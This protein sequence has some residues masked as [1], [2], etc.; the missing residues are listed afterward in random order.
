LGGL[1]AH[2]KVPNMRKA[3]GF[4][5]ELEP[6][7]MMFLNNGELPFGAHQWERYGLELAVSMTKHESVFSV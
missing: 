2:F 3:A 1:S 7:R 5:V 4:A 6:Q